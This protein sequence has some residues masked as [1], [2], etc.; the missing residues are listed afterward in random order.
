MSWCM[1]L[2][3]GVKRAPNHVGGRVWEGKPWVL[4]GSLRLRCQLKPGAKFELEAS[5]DP[6]NLTV[7]AKMASYLGVDLFRGL[8][9]LWS[10]FGSLENHNNKGTNSQKRWV[11]MASIRSYTFV[12]VWF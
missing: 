12:R 10:S 11:P 9:S 3:K 8:P 1:V 6:E 5:R 4:F 2:P 7:P